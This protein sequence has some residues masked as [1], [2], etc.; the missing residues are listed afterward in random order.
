M[1]T[2]ISLTESDDSNDEILR[3]LSW[4]FGIAYCVLFS[5]ALFLQCITNYQ[6]QSTKGFSTDYSLT[7]FV[8]FFFLML[9]QT[10]GRIDPTT[11]AGRVHVMDLTFAQLAFTAASIMFMQTL[12]YP[13]HNCLT[14]TKIVVGIIVAVFFLAGI[15]EVWFGI[16]FKNYSGIS[17]LDLAAF[18]KAGSS[19]VKYLFQIRENVV[20]KSTEGVSKPGYW[21]DFLGNI[22][23]FSQLQIDSVIAGYAHFFADPQMNMAKVLIACFGLINTFV[24]LIQIHCIYKD[25]PRT[26]GV[27]LDSTF[28]SDGD[29]YV[30]EGVVF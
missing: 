20:N 28:G 23:C 21:S 17:L 2:N 16:P 22:F 26:I 18:F 1:S 4:T 13:S 30:D 25:A 7:G 12:I 5:G 6:N 10:V 8:G 15:L 19:F 9:N 14:S 29:G 11:D 27:H 3:L 24:I